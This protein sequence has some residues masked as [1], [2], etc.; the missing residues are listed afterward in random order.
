MHNSLYL[1]NGVPIL[2]QPDLDESDNERE[3]IN[4]SHWEV[5]CLRESAVKSYAMPLLGY[6]SE[7]EITG[8]VKYF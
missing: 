5:R 2:Y 7:A 3:L 4:R 8:E 1:A 6:H